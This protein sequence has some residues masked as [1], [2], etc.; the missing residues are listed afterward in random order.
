MTVKAFGK[1][2]WIPEDT[3]GFASQFA[4]LE[5]TGNSLGIIRVQSGSKVDMAPVGKNG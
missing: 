4:C 2:R 3:L 5:R 1:I